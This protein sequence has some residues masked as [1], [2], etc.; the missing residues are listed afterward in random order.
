MN[1]I[2]AQLKIK[3]GKIIDVEIPTDDE[4]ERIAMR[5]HKDGKPCLETI[6]G[7][8]VFYRPRQEYSY[9]YV[10]VDPFTGEKGE[11]SAPTKT[12]SPAEFTFGYKAPWSI[13]LSWDA[14]NEKPP[15]WFRYEGKLIRS[16]KRED[17][18]NSYLCERV[19]S[20]PP[21]VKPHRW[22]PRASYRCTGGSHWHAKVMLSEH[23]YYLELYWRPTDVS[24]EQPKPLGVFRFDLNGLLRGD[25]IRSDKADKNGSAC[26]RLRIFRA[27]SDGHFYV[28]TKEGE[29]RLF[30]ADGV[31]TPKET[32]QAIDLPEPP[33]RCEAQVSRIIRDT[34]LARELKHLYGFACQVCGCD[35]RI[36]PVPN[37]FYIEVHHIRPLGGDHAGSD[38]HANMLVLCPNH[39]AMFDYSIPRFLSPHRIEIAGVAH[40]LTIKHELSHDS[41]EYH[42]RMCENRK[43]C[44]PRLAPPGS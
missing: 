17:I 9:S 15:G 39:H 12:A 44:H 13:V 42:N 23:P 6:L 1:T 36:E 35:F 26:V 37:S 3:R 19:Q 24:S 5:M 14:G 18:K 2:H 34:P 8:K 11:K 20:I 10:R 4:I 30:I 40:D 31:I 29:P 33:V 28:Q 7:W 22:K 32:V 38:S 43:V 41:I 27:D 16:P 25:Y 21:G